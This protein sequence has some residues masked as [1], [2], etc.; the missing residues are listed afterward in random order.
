MNPFL[1]PP[2]ERLAHW[3]ELRKSLAAMDDMTK[4]KAVAQYWSNAPLKTIA[5]DPADS[6]NWL[7]PW[8][9]MYRNEWC[10]SSIAIGMENTLRLAGF[11]TDRMKLKY[12]IDRDIQA[13]LLILVVDDTWVLNY[14]WG[15]VL[16]YPKTNHN[17]MKAWRFSGKAYLSL[18]G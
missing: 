17:V 2:E 10:R 13:V 5:Y 8:E 12:I 16:P 6:A 7:T 1:L 3:K 14:D 18:D 11:S 15:S 4:L 9:M